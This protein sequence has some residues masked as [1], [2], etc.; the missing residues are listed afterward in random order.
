MITA[1]APSGPVSSGAGRGRSGSRRL[2]RRGRSSRRRGAACRRSSPGRN[3]R[4]RNRP[5]PDRARRRPPRRR[6]RAC[7]APG[8][9]SPSPARRSIAL[10][11]SASG[12]P[13]VQDLVHALDHVDHRAVDVAGVEIGADRIRHEPLLDRRHGVAE[14]EAGRAVAEIEDDA[15]L[16]RLPHVLVDLAVRRR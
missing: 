16:A 12:T 3:R 13:E 11:T 1:P 9:R 10:I 15:P 2:R 4:S 7:P 8:G 5:S 14:P 6:P